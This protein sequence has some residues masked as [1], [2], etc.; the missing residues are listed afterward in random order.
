MMPTHL[1]RAN[2]YLR[3]FVRPGALTKVLTGE[4]SLTPLT[5]GCSSFDDNE[6]RDLQKQER[7]LYRNENFCA[8]CASSGLSSQLK[9]HS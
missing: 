4:T 9:E 8:N 1:C 6:F 7:R 3:N 2:A 5:L